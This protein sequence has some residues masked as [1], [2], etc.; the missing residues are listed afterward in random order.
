MD[1]FSALFHLKANLLPQRAAAVKKQTLFSS[2]RVLPPP[3]AHAAE[4]AHRPREIDN[5][6]VTALKECV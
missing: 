3:R 4:A 1:R 5:R 2:G 6:D